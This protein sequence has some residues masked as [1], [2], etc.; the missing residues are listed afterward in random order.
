MSST[1]TRKVGNKTKPVYVMNIHKSGHLFY[2][3][4]RYE[5]I[6]MVQ[7]ES[8][9]RLVLEYFGRGYFKG[10]RFIHIDGN[11]SNNALNNLRYLTGYSC[12]EDFK[13]YKS[14]IVYKYLNPTD[15]LLYE[16]YDGQLST[17]E[18]TDAIG[19]DTPTFRKHLTNYSISLPMWFRPHRTTCYLQLHLSYF[20]INYI[21]S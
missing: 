10:R 21:P 8:V 4:I 1:R 6:E 5:K 16:Y 11:L 2:V 9:G 14:R 18:I 19:V 7:H 3:P 17:D 12:K 20:G 15:K 13:Q